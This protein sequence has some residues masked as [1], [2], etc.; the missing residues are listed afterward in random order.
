MLSTAGMPGEYWAE[1]WRAAVYIRRRYSNEATGGI[2][3]LEAFIGIKAEVKYVRILG[4][5]SYIQIP[6]NLRK[7]LN[8]SG[9]QATLLR[10]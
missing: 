7:K 5:M 9:E 3:S 1:A 4:C 6:K 2:T 10:F 8:S